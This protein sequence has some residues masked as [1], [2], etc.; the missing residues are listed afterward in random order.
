MVRKLC[1][2]EG[3][4]SIHLSH[5]VGIRGIFAEAIS[6]CTLLSSLKGKIMERGPV[7]CTFAYNLSIAVG[8]NKDTEFCFHPLI[9]LERSL[10]VMSSHEVLYFFSV[11][12]PSSKCGESL[13]KLKNKRGLEMKTHLQGPL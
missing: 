5:R 2:C 12:F 3:I 8:M 11:F 10:V 1:N 4:R 9:W 7:L 6:V 13:K